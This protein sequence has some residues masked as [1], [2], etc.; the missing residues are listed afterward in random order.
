[1]VKSVYRGVKKNAFFLNVPIEI[2]FGAEYLSRKRTT[3]E[4]TIS[5]YETA[6]RGIF[7]KPGLKKTGRLPKWMGSI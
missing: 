5:W 7:L 6:L 2:F 3:F 1:L 4:G